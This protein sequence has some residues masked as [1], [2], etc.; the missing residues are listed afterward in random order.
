MSSGKANWLQSVGTLSV[1]TCLGDRPGT[2]LVPG[3]GHVPSYPGVVESSPERAFLAELESRLAGG[4]QVAVE[5]SL[6]LLAGQEVV[7]DPDELRGARRRAVQLLATAGDPR[8]EPDPDGRA[9]TALSADLD[10]PEPRAALAKGLE[11]LGAT[12]AG[13]PNISARLEPLAA[14]QELAWRGFACTLQAEE[15]VE[16]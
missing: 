9:V 6:I 16:G 1:R 4:E 11:S 5:V 3:T 8:R 14:D 10:A 2:C 13:L 7:L 12:V 15:L